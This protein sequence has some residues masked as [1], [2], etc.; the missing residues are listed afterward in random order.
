VRRR[1]RSRSRPCRRPA[2]RRLPLSRLPRRLQQQ[3]SI[4]TPVSAAHG[5]KN[6]TRPQRPITIPG[7]NHTPKAVSAP[8]QTKS[9]SSPRGP[10]RRCRRV[11]LLCAKITASGEQGR[12]NNFL[13]R[14]VPDL[15]PPSNP[16]DICR[17]REGQ[18]RILVRHVIQTKAIGDSPAGVKLDCRRLFYRLVVWP[19]SPP[20]GT[21]WLG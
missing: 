18:I 3:K 1:M 5:K 16:S 13:P 11:F 2:P 14:A 19:W 9:F 15:S 4:P 6:I 7:G 20:A 21:E 17:W 8:G 10:V 12:A